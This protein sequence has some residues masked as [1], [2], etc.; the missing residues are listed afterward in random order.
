MA[1]VKEQTVKKIGAL[2]EARAAVEAERDTMRI[3]IAS[4]E[5]ELEASQREVGGLRCLAPGCV[6]P[7]DGWLAGSGLAAGGV[8][9]RPFIG[10]ESEVTLPPL[11]P[12]SWSWSASASTS[13]TASAT[14]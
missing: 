5:K 11:L 1:K 3:S 8:S 7:G 12:R 14:C 4:L 10:V 2:D 6:W 13:C 9:C